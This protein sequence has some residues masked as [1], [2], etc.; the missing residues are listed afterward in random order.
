MLQT[1]RVR[2]ELDDDP[3]EEILQ[4]LAARTEHTYV[5]VPFLPD[6]QA[7]SELRTMFPKVVFLLW[8]KDDLGHAGGLDVE[9]LTPKLQP[10]DERKKRDDYKRAL[11]ILRDR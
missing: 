2:D 4:A 1:V 10:E 6:R 5:Y 3:D 7:L 8:D 11:S 9:W